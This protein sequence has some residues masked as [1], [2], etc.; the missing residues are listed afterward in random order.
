MEYAQSVPK[1][2]F[3]YHLQSKIRYFFTVSFFESRLFITKVRIWR[4]P[5]YQKIDTFCIFHVCKLIQEVL[6]FISVQCDPLVQWSHPFLLSVLKR[7]FYVANLL[8]SLTT[9]ATNKTEQS[10]IFLAVWRQK[11]FHVVRERLKKIASS[12]LNSDRESLKF[13]NQWNQ[14][15]P[16]LLLKFDR[17]TFLFVVI[18]LLFLNTDLC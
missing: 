4:M 17:H 9:K 13:A 3:T 5:C 14:P 6:Y 18:V 15:F 1:P 7:E 2:S 16:L 11:R 8:D 12:W 10:E